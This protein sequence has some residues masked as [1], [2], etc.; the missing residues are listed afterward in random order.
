MRRIAFDTETHLTKPGQLFPKLVCVQTA[1]RNAPPGLVVNGFPAPL[2]PTV[3]QTLDL[4]AAGVQRIRALLRDPDVILVGHNVAFDLGVI[5]A[6]DPAALPEIFA[7]Y[8]AGRIVDTMVRSALFDIASGIFQ[9]FNE[10]QRQGQY[11]L[12]NTARR[13]AGLVIQKEDTWRL[14]YAALEHVPLAQWP[15]DAKEYALLDAF[16]TLVADEGITL[17]VQK[18]GALSGEMPDEARQVRAGWVLHL[19]AGHGLRVDEDMV[20]TIRANLEYQRSLA[21]DASLKYG[22]V[23]R[24]KDGTISKNTK[25]L[26]ELVQKGYEAQGLT[27]PRTPTGQIQIG[28]DQLR[29]SADPA[30]IVLADIA[31]TDK[32][33]STYVPAL[34]NAL[35][36]LPL[37]SKP[38][39]LVASGR[40][41][42][43][44]P[45]LQ[46]PPRKGGIRECFVA[47]PGYVFAD[48]DLDTVELRGLAQAC[49]EL[50]GWSDMADALKRGEDLHLSLGAEILGITYEEAK[51]RLAQGDGLVEDAR[52][53]AKVANFGFPGGMGYRKLAANQRANGPMYNMTD[54]EAER[55]RTAWLRRWREMSLYLQHA[56][57]VTGPGE[58]CK[59]AQPWSGRI[60]GGLEYCSA[61]NTYFQGR[62]AD[63]TKLALWR[64]A[65]ACYVDTTSPLY[66]CRIVLFMHDEFILEV[67]EARAA[68][69]GAEQVRIVIEAVQEVIPDVPIT[70]TVALMRRW[71]KG[72]K[73][74]KLV[75]NGVE[76]L[77]PSRPEKRGDKT[78]WVADV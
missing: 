4:A 33:L 67:P 50:F 43:S 27:A 30:C 19:I 55:L 63:A 31:S 38:N 12:L 53:S 17:E 41:S 35:G 2:D 75:V 44:K 74:V 66:G 73:P 22:T 42:W 32:L 78:V 14:H 47:R 72:A 46:N 25:I 26:K 10:G 58:E 45:N 6:E 57:R 34:E 29:D 48:N 68:E 54:E 28:E 16:A 9:D 7:A 69:C 15:S 20:K 60:R 18:E 77:V 65:K 62:V 49:L 51:I 39:V 40:T 71:F 8:D 64:L 23:R 76:T 24:N 37:T 13:F 70:S 52:Q 21:M 5:A 36:G 3:T 1:E 11:S 59:I 56:S 61:A